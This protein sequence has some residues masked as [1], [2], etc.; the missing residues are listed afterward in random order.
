MAEIEDEAARPG[1]QLRRRRLLAARRVSDAAPET[2][3]V[4]SG[5]GIP[6]TDEAED[7]RRAACTH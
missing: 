4:T 6:A 2:L 1:L 5:T 3:I 7:R